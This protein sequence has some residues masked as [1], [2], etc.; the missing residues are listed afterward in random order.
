MLYLGI[1]EA[2]KGPV[3]GPL[4]V[5]G[6]MVDD[7][8][9]VGLENIRV[10]DSKDLTL[11]RRE[12]MSNKIKEVTDDYE[13]KVV[14]AEE[15]DQNMS[16]GVNMNQLEANKIAEIINKFNDGSDNIKV[17]VDCPSIGIRKWKELLMSK[18]DNLSNLEIVCEHKADRNH[19]PVSAASIL[20]KSVREKE[21]QSLK[22]KFGHEIGSG[23][24]SDTS[25]SDFVKRNADRLKDQ[26]LFRQ[27]WKTWKRASKEVVDE[28]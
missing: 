23:Y 28:K 25:T 10:R 15:I 12:F 6:C 1:D 13:V 9:Y 20:A 16:S 21:M 22:E 18:I 27:S 19:V 8:K 11:R 7:Q 17:M 5:S 3:I 2:G 26:G 4:V 14:S 24:A